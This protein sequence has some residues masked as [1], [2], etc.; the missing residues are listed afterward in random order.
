MQQQEKIDD[1]FWESVCLLSYPEI[2]NTPPLLCCHGGIFV[3]A[4][5]LGKSKITTV[6]FN[7][8][9][10][11]TVLQGERIYFKFLLNLFTLFMWGLGPNSGF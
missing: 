8:T 10:L 4:A 3:Y 6:L 11:I 9:Y 2:S 5:L 1:I 7:C